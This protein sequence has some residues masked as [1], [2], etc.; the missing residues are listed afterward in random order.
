M[1]IKNSIRAA[2]NRS[3]TCKVVKRRG[4]VY[5]I[6]PMNPRNK[7]RWGYKSRKRA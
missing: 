5:I 7:V 3:R 4:R 2:R 6:D 1:K